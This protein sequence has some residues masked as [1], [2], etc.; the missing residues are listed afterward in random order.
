VA[1]GSGPSINFTP[2]TGSYEVSLAASDKDGGT[3]VT[4]R[5]FTV[6]NRN[7]V[8][9]GG[10]TVN[11]AEGAA[12][13][14]QTVAT[15][16]DPAGAMPLS[17]YSATIAWGDGS[18]CSATIS[19]P[20][21]QGV[22][23]V[24][25]NHTYA[26][27]GN[28]PLTVTI[29]HTGGSDQ[30]VTGSASVSDHAVVVVG[31]FTVTAQFGVDSGPQTVATFTD[32]GGPESV[33]DYT[34]T[35]AWGDGSGSAGTITLS[36]NVFTVT[37]S[38]AYDH[39]GIYPV[40]VTVTHEQAP[41]VTATS[42]ALVS[43]N[44]GILLLDPTG[45]G[46]L[47]VSGNAKLTVEGEEEIV[48]DSSNAQAVVLSG[49]A[50]VTAEE[51]DVTGN[52]FR[53]SGNAALH[54]V[55][56]TNAAA[57]SDPLAALPTPSAPSATYSAVR[58]SDNTSVTLQPGVYVGGISVSGNASVT[59]L[60]GLYYL[61]GG[62]LSVSGNG[63]LTGSGV[64]IY[65]AP[66]GSADGITLS[67]NG[68]VVLS[69]G[70]SG[71]HA[72]I[73]LFQDRA[74]SAP[75]SITGN[76][77]LAIT[78]TIYAAGAVINVTGNGGVNAQGYPIDSLATEVIAYDMRLSGNGLIAVGQVIGIQQGQTATVGFWYGA[79]GQQLLNAFN[80]GASSTVLGNWLAATYGNLFGSGSGANNLAGLTNA[81]VA[82]YFQGLYA[83][84]SGGV[85]MQLLAT[86]LNLYAT[87][88][89]LGGAT[90]APYGFLVTYDGVGSAV[91]NVGANGAAFG[92][93]NNTTLSVA[94]LLAAANR[95]AGNGVLFNGNGTLVSQ[96]DTVFAAINALGGL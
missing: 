83:A 5:M 9:T 31:G 77:N 22:F 29:H 62:G 10:F 28:D 78:G 79:G 46:A 59:L 50:S 36:S 6:I 75:V 13:G 57:V 90:S 63:R 20:D 67:G 48:V 82:A 84:D 80:G 72:G 3:S 69:P 68:A 93:A 39:A 55:L 56:D 85:R 53:T 81:Q 8:V 52:G 15:F 4:T 26:E 95:Q 25:G 44:V 42:S 30:V 47:T 38:H 21:G 70:T 87:S 88:I 1:T 17:A 7:L 34:A 37:A 49:N 23:T 60:P 19:G 66:A 91:Y 71:A 96:A 40:A 94:A 32:P 43:D 41:A 35:V 51:I 27:E 18:T 64:L 12:S 74:S 2:D 11:A 65:N 14:S 89:G 16:T 61:Q 54:G 58:A 45:K 24:Q 33:A 92:V 86:A 73:T 76:G